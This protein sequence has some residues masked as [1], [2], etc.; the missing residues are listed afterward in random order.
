MILRDKKFIRF[1][2][3][4]AAVFTLCYYGALFFVGVVVPGGTY[5][6]FI[7]KYLNVTAWLRTSLM[8][9]S[10]LLLSLFGTQTFREGEYVL[11]SANGK[12]IRLS[13]DCLGFG[14]M[15]FWAA[16]IVATMTVPAKKIWWFFGGLFLIMDT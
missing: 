5:S 2:V 6:P 3:I 14:V 7:E 4:F 1:I 9:G 15:S 8:N 16:Y 11:R 10:K 13:Y 12:G